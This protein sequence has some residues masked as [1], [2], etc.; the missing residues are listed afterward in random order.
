[1]AF[2]HRRFLRKLAAQGEPWRWFGDPDRLRVQPTDV[3]FQ[4][5]QDLRPED[6]NAQYLTGR[7]D[8]LKVGG[9]GRIVIASS[10]MGSRGS[11]NPRVLPSAELTSPASARPV[12]R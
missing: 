11:I 10:V 9:I 5:I 1:V 8:G 6:I 12:V 2:F 3:G 4:R 7:S